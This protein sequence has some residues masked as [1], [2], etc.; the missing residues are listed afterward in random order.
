ML[1]ENTDGITKAE[2]EKQIKQMGIMGLG[3]D[4]DEDAIDTSE[5]GMLK[6]AKAKREGLI[7]MIEQ[8]AESM[9]LDA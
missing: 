6:S 3:N 4:K 9:D 7:K 2:L 8:K 1:K 5:A